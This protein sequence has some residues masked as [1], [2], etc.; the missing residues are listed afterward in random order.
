MFMRDGVTY[1][2]HH[3]G[4]PSQETRPGERYS[5]LFRMYTCDGECGLTRVQ[6][7]RFEPESPLHPIIRH[8]PHP[9]FKVSNLEAAI[10]GHRLLL[11]PYEPIRG[12]CVAIIEDGGVPIELIESQLSDEEIWSRAAN[13]AHGSIY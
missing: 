7:H 11:D 13:A 6:W 3:L 12:Y 2:F 1:E 9:A 4:I 8:V 10:A 5:A